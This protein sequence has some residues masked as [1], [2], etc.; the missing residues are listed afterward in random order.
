MPHPAPD[1]SLPPRPR[2]VL[3]LAFA[4]RRVL[5]SPEVETLSTALGQVLGLLGHRLAALTPGVPVQ[6]GQEPRVAAFYA[7]QRP[8]LRLI[9]GLCEG[10]DTVA[11]QVLEGLH[12]APDSPGPDGAAATCVDTELAAVLPFDLPAYRASRAP[13][14]RA[15]FDRQAE[16]CAYIL[17]ADGLYAKPEPDTPLAERRRKRGYRAQSAL[18]LRQA[19]ILIA[20]A[21]PQ[22]EIKAGGTLETV[23]GAMAFGLPVVFIDTGSGAVRV[24]EPGADLHA[25]L[26]E[27]PPGEADAGPDLA[28]RLADLVSWVMADPNLEPPAPPPGQAPAEPAVLHLLREYFDGEAV[29]P[30]RRDGK[31]RET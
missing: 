9:T 18:L 13:D 24:I 10:A 8:L 1:S 16:R 6:A 26:E 19:D 22:A 25:A 23:Q 14:F 11:A 28:A 7:D 4:G 12:I 17:V 27:P 21:A 29:P 5:E 15:D 20:A 31:Q 3:R 2:A 30:R